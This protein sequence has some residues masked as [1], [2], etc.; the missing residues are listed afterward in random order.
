[1]FFYFNQTVSAWSDDEEDKNMLYNFLGLFNRRG[2]YKEKH[3]RRTL[4]EFYHE[5]KGKDRHL[6]SRSMAEY[7]LHQQAPT[8]FFEQ[9]D[10]EHAIDKYIEQY[11]I[12][13]QVLDED[14]ITF[15]IFFFTAYRNIDQNGDGEVGRLQLIKYVE[16]ECEMDKPDFITKEQLTSY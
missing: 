5:I 11:E 14:F 1:M 6:T 8:D 9:Q 4:K 12:D 15:W 10:Y 7:M 13:N 2:K 3:A 16:R